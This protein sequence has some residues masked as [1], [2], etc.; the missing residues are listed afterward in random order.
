MNE[1]Q[2]PRVSRFRSTSFQKGKQCYKPANAQLFFSEA[3]Q[4]RKGYILRRFSN[5]ANC[6][7][8][9]QFNLQTK[10]F[11][12]AHMQRSKMVIN[13]LLTRVLESNLNSR[14]AQR[15]AN[16]GNFS[17]IPYKSVYDTASNLLHKRK[18]YQ[19][20]VTQQQVHSPMN[21]KQLFSTLELTDTDD[22][23]KSNLTKSPIFSNAYIQERITAIQ[24]Q[25]NYNFTGEMSSLNRRSNALSSCTNKRNWC[26]YQK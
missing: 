7:N 1:Q 8:K 22:S 14:K 17:S 5:P 16:G 20:T 18:G 6:M 13:S 2:R 24:C 12:G 11:R 4:Q 15:T 23:K 10:E 26:L 9:P 19:G 3:V 21:R 25:T